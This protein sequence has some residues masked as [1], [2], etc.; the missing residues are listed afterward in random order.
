MYYV[1]LVNVT[2]TQIIAEE[3]FETK[4][5]AADRIRLGYGPQIDLEAIGSGSY[6]GPEKEFAIYGPAEEPFSWLPDPAPE[7]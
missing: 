2:D 1:A 7:A 4:E 6:G 3:S 5:E